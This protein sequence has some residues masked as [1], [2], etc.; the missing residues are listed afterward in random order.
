MNSQ[1]VG[2]HVAGIVFAIMAMAQLAR[3]VIRAEVLLGGFVLP[4]WPSALAFVLLG[5]LS[6]WMWWLANQPQD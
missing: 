3:V 1:I 5:S 4:L 6:V 2:L